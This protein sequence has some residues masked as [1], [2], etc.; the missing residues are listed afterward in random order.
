M[1]LRALSIQAAR[2]FF[3]KE[4]YL[5][6]DTPALSESLIPET[7]L[8][9]FKTEYLSPSFSK[10]AHQAKAFFL[11]PSPEIYIKPIIAQTKRSVFQISKCYRNVESI[12]HIH[13][14]EFT[15][16]EYYTMNADYHDSIKI[17]EAL[18]KYVADR[19]KD[20]PLADK[21]MLKIFSSGFECITMD[22]A[23]RKYAGIALSSEHSALELAFYAEKLGLGRA[24]SYSDWKEDDLYELLLVHAVEPKL[25]KNKLIALLDYPAF[26]PCLAVENSKK[27]LNKK[28]EEIDWKTVERWEV[29]LN[30]VELANC[31]TEERDEK[32][33]D[34][35]FK[36]ENSLKQEYALVPHPAV[37]NFGNICSKMPPCSGVA[38]GFDRLIMLL[39]GKKTLGPVIHL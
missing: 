26:V 16:L 29:Y 22:E 17:S 9:V 15:M 28:N 39:A 7:C 34:S 2:D 6:L 38:M 31:Y 20:N 35:Y 3:I 14:P 21:E 18:L 30:G 24:E 1:E 4:N 23:F 5:E 19:V 8:E 11:T 13:N 33:I 36:S 25:P 10:D 32:K 12:G 27:V 37:Q